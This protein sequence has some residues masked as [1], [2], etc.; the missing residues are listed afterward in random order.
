[1]RKTEAG[2]T[3]IDIVATT[4]LIALAVGVAAPTISTGLR[5]YTLNSA[6]QSVT[7]TVRN[8]RFQAV[9]Q[10]RTLRVMFNCPAANQMRVVE[11]VGNPAID[12][13]ANRCDT[14]AYPYPDPDPAVLPN[15]DGP[16]L[17]MSTA[18]LGGQFDLQVSP[19]GRITPLV[20][21]PACVTS[22]PPATVVVADSHQEKRIVV[23][24]SGQV[25]LSTRSYDVVAY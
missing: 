23:A 21:C 16:V 4:G 2:F 8:A 22:A 19:L 24:A 18:Q 3:L 15:A 12:T 13:A 17:T 5:M 11:V 9:T 7:A 14:T 6:A 10:N 20:G 25:T 1:V